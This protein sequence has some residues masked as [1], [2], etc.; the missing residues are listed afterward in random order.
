[1]WD[2]APKSKIHVV[3][4]MLGMEKLAERPYQNEKISFAPLLNV[5]SDSAIIAIIAALVRKL[6]V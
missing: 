1:M 4:F 6:I 5:D 2:V 3:S